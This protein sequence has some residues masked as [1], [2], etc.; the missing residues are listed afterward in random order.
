M[1]GLLLRDVIDITTVVCPTV[2]NWHVSE[3]SSFSY[4]RFFRFDIDL[5]EIV[6]SCSIQEFQVDRLGA[7]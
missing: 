5:D 2:K 3:K 1:N 7:V 4:H 6:V